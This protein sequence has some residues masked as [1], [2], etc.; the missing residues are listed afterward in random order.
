MFIGT[1]KPTNLNGFTAVPSSPD[2]ILATLWTASGTD[3]AEC[4]VDPALTNAYANTIT[5]VDY[6]LSYNYWRPRE[7][8]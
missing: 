5:F 6:H 3:V 2:G 1:D 8:A 7:N 4:D